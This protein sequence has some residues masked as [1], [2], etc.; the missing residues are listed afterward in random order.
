MLRKTNK[1]S[2]SVEERLVD[3]QKYHQHL[4]NLRAGFR[5]DK[6]NQPRDPVGGR[7]AWCDT[8]A[9]DEHPVELVR[10]SSRTYE[11][12][13][14]EAVHIKHPP[15]ALDQRHCSGLLTF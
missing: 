15:G 10:N 12:R 14:P 9:Y 4:L 2:K 1:K 7:F 11:E 5:A 6:P 13:E 8:Y 3:V